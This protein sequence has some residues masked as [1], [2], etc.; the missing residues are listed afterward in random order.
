MET[1]QE[2]NYRALIGNLPFTPDGLAIEMVTQ[3]RLHQEDTYLTVHTQSGDILLYLRIDWADRMIALSKC[4]GGVWSKKISLQAPIQ[5]AGTHIILSFARDAI[6]I[7]VEDTRIIDWPLD[8]AFQQITAMNASGAWSLDLASAFDI[9]LPEQILPDLPLSNNL[10][11]V[12]QPDLIFDIGMNNGDDTD[13]YLKKGF[14]VVAIEAIPTL[15]ALAAERFKA[16]VAS[17]RLIICNIG[18]APV[19]GEMSF[20]INHN[21]NEWSSFDRD[22]ASRG[23]PVTELKVAT[24]TP[25]DFFTAFGIPYYCKIDIEGF[26]RPVVEAIARLEVKPSYVSFENGAPRDFDVLAAGGYD[27]FQLVEQSALPD[28]DLPNPSRERNSISHRFPPG[29]SGPFGKDLAGNWWSIDET[30]SALEK[31]HRE[32]TARE[33][34]GYDWWDLHARHRDA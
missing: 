31:H 3:R 32:L 12:P 30:R 16:D 17:G 1:H 24:A 6:S 23:H 9:K 4:T 15:C 28:I 26:D 11:R 34:R 27:S 29:S 20:Y 18:V 5:D 21:H 13:Y 25:E 2:T 19:R 33:V 22:I 10:L 7:L 8:V 14:R